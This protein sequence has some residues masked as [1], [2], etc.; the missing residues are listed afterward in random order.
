[1]DVYYADAEGNILSKSVYL[2]CTTED[3][4]AQWAKLNNAENVRL[5]EFSMSDNGEEIRPSGGDPL[6]GYIPG[7]RTTFNLTLS[8]EFAAHANREF[9][10]ETL[11]STFSGFMAFDDFALTVE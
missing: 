5:V 8:G 3:V 6:V 4:F 2:P 11:K 7:N 9:L 10:T 1:V